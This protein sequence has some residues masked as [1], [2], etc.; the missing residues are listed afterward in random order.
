MP[1]SGCTEP[2]DCASVLCWHQWRRGGDLGR[3][4]NQSLGFLASVTI[5]LTLLGCLDSKCVNEV[6]EVLESPDGTKKIVV[7]SRNCGATTGFNTQ[8]SIVEAKQKLPDASGN[9]FVVDKGA[10]KLSWKKDGGVLVVFD[11][12]VRMF[13]Q[14]SAV[15]GVAI[16]YREE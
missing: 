12:G 13:K 6:G 11:R 1:T 2:S 9:A 15:S 7:F 5:C 16:E 14:E 3:L 4:A 8:A 10:V